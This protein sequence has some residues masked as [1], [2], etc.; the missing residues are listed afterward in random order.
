MVEEKH[1]VERWRET[2]SAVKGSRTDSGGWKCGKLWADECQPLCDEFRDSRL[3]RSQDNGAISKCSETCLIL[4]GSIG[5]YG[6]ERL[7]FCLLP[8]IRERQEFL[9]CPDKS[10]KMCLINMGL[11]F[12][13][14]HPICQLSELSLAWDGFTVPS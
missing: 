4:A 11:F 8:R 7:Q 14:R 6:M 10:R 2:R 12:C 9:Y 3:I 1:Q 5:S 13:A